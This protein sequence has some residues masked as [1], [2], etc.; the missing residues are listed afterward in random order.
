M[1]LKRLYQ[2]NSLR[3]TTAEL[4]VALQ[5]PCGLIDEPSADSIAIVILR[6]HRYCNCNALVGDR[7]VQAAS[8]PFVTLNATLQRAAWA[9]AQGLDC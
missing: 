7:F 1:R 6:P 4:I 5:V 9:L 2:I 8:P 3:Q